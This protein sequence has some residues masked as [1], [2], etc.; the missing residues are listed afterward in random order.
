MLIFALSDH[1]FATQKQH[2]DSSRPINE[3]SMHQL[4]AFLLPGKGG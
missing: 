4:G 3:Q 2:G 1:I